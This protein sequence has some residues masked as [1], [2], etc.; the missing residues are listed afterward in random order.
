MGVKPVDTNI[1]LHGFEGPAAEENIFLSTLST[2][3]HACEYRI[4]IPATQP[5]GTYFYHPHAHG[6]AGTEVALGLSGAWIVEPDRPQISRSADHVVLLRYRL[7]LRLDNRFVPDDGGAVNGDAE[8][9]EAALSDA[10]PVVYDPFNPPPWPVTYPM[11]GGGVRLDPRGCD[12]LAPEP[13]VSVDGSLAPAT[14]DV[15]AGQLQLLRLIDATSD[16]PKRLQLRDAAGRLQP[17][18]VVG[19]DGIP[20]SGNMTEPLTQYLAMDYVMVA[21]M[22]RAD[23]L[24]SSV[25]GKP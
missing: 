20:V 16:S 4:T 3:M 23:V 2:P 8:K 19:L 6:S 7:P 13:M 9:H 5:P 15:P 1:H 17:M 25:P 12:G 14:L 24:V 10:T 22:A 18:R 21:P 11:S